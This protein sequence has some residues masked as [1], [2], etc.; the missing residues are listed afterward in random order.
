MTKLLYLNASP[1]KAY[2]ASTQLAE[3]YLGALRTHNSSLEVDCLDL[4][5]TD[6]PAF[7]GD[8]VAAKMN[9]IA[10]HEHNEVQQSAWDQIAG[11]ARRFISADRYLIA[12]PMWNG[13]IPYR[14][15]HYIDLI[16]QPGLLWGF[17]PQTGYFGL[18]EG[19][20]AT[21]ALTSGVYRQ[22]VRSAFGFDH[23]STYLRDWLNQAGVTAISELRLQ[24]TLLTDDPVGD[25]AKAKEDAVAL[26]RAHGRV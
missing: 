20:H 5:D 2:S 26:A 19:K 8:K 6:L 1:R 21:L 14:L 15:K 11:I 3:T 9:V 25:L 10:G 4:W 23:H 22:N 16:H 13:G 24:P 12:A 7:D 17:D 18:L